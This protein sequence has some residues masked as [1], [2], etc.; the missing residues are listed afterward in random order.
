MIILSLPDFLEGVCSAFNDDKTIDDIKN[1]TKT[2]KG[3]F[4]DYLREIVRHGHGIEGGS[5]YR[6]K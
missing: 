4:K 2:T 1:N 3:K 6:K 5:E